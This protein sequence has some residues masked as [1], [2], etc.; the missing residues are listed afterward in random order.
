MDQSLNFLTKVITTSLLKY[1]L[2]EPDENHIAIH[3]LNITSQN[4][5]I[6]TLMNNLDKKSMDIAKILDVFLSSSSQTPKTLDHDLIRQ[7][8]KAD[9]YFHKKIRGLQNNTPSTK[10]ILKNDILYYKTNENTTLLCLPQQI[11]KHVLQQFHTQ[12]IHRI[13]TEIKTVLFNNFKIRDY[14]KILKEVESNCINCTLNPLRKNLIN[15][16]LARSVS[17]RIL[18]GAISH[19]DI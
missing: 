11:T 4:N 12:G 19:I 17:R 7:A 1:K 5:K 14:E 16:G 15:F 9:S 6:R 2:S 8:Q 3:N 13:G 10:F 18:P